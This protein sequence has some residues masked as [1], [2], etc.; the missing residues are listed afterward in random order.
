MD[1]LK[2]AK[3]YILLPLIFLINVNATMVF[4]HPQNDTNPN[5]VKANI[6][7]RLPRYIEWPITSKVTDP[8][9][10][11][12]IGIVGDNPVKVFLE[13][14]KNKMMIKGKP[15]EIM[16]IKDFQYL[17][18]CNMILISKTS[19]KNLEVILKMIDRLPIV[20]IADTQGFTKDG[21]MID[22]FLSGGK[23]SFNVNK[24][25]AKNSQL[26]FTSGLLRYAQKIIE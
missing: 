16:Q 14:L 11:F 1:F 23:F 3:K 26:I 25:S 13:G 24:R 22:L 20:T 5:N 8:H 9:S 7:T 2:L 18:D 21:V 15:F 12:I 10:P 4:L 19:S 6:I 17:R